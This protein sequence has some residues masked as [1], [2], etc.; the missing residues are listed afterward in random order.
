M[1]TA[2]ATDPL[3]SH[4]AAESITYET[5]TAIQKN[6]LELFVRHKTLDDKSLVNYYRGAFDS[7]I[8]ESS[9]RTRRHELVE[10]GL[11]KD[12][13]L[14]IKQRNGRRAILWTSKSK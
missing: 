3:T 6:I 7:E 13:G 4:E 14:K 5:A 1:A 11:I 9:V 12:S 2:R 10:A 8:A